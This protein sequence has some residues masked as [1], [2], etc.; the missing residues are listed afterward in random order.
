[1]DMPPLAFFHFPGFSPYFANG[2]VDCRRIAFCVEKSSSCA[3]T[4]SGTNNFVGGNGLAFLH[5]LQLTRKRSVRAPI[6]SSKQK[7]HVQGCARFLFRPAR[8]ISWTYDFPLLLVRIG[9]P[10]MAL[11][12][13]VYN[14]WQAYYFAVRW[15]SPA[16]F[17][18]VFRLIIRFFFRLSSFSIRAVD[19]DFSVLDQSCP[20]DHLV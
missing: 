17:E 1:M 16:L 12:S 3:T 7:D 15:S 20:C 9:G 11:F 18:A 6:R 13:L 19:F 2:V 4:E 5:S 14:Y 10:V 8:V